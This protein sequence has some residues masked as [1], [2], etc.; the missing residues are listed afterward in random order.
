MLTA[1]VQQDYRNDWIKRCSSIKGIDYSSFPTRNICWFA[2]RE[3]P[4]FKAMSQIFSYISDKSECFSFNTDGHFSNDDLLLVWDF[5]GSCLSEEQSAQISQCNNKVILVTDKTENRLASDN[6]AVLYCGKIYGAGFNETD[7]LENNCTNILDLLAAQI[8]MLSKT[9]SIPNS[10]Y[11]AGHGECSLPKAIQL[12]DI[13]YTSM[14]SYDDG[15]Y[16]MTFAKE[17][18]DE[19]FYFDNT[20]GGDLRLLHELLLKCLVEFD[21]ICRRHNIRYFLG[22]GTLL[23]AIRHG[24]MIPWDDDM[25]VM[26]LREDYEK[27]LSVVN[28]ELCDEMFFQSSKTDSEYHSIFTKIR[29]NGTKFVTKYSQQFKNMHQGIFIDIFVHDHSS[30]NKI[31]Q[32]LHVFK[33]LFARSLVFHKWAGTPMHFYGKL[34]LVCKIATRFMNRASMDKLEKIQDK[35]VQKYNKKNTKYLYDGTGE[36]LKHG[37]FPSRWLDDTEYADFSG[38]KFPVPKEYDQYLTYSYG[39]YKEWIPASL[40]KAGHDII[41]VDFGKYKV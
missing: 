14:I 17:R 41:K 21:R 37:A 6:T 33:T 18:P 39:N 16:M 35:V 30:N 26:M 19:L 27:F 36:H 1:D 4:A 31:G 32:K 40:R 2:D 12:Q 20:Y 5:E 23:G 11:Y 28:D 22:G 15:E 9:E 24:G 29:L 3:N 10:I 34:K 25:D 8:Y 13:G 7:P 38:H